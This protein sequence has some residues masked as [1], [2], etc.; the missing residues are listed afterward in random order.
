MKR[1]D[2]DRVKQLLEAAGTSRNRATENEH[3]RTEENMKTE[4][5]EN[6]T[7]DTGGMPDAEIDELADEGAKLLSYEKW[8]EQ[9]LPERVEI[10]E[11]L[12]VKA[13]RRNVA[14]IVK[15]RKSHKSS[16]ATTHGALEGFVSR[17]TIEAKRVARG[18]K[19]LI[20]RAI[21][22]FTKKSS[23]QP[24]M[25]VSDA[26]PVDA[27]PPVFRDLAVSIAKT[28]RSED[29][30][31]VIALPLIGVFSATLGQGIRVKSSR[32]TSYPNVF[33]YCDVG[34]GGIKSVALEE[35]EAPVKAFQTS[36]LQYHGDTVVPQT[37]AKLHK[38]NAKIKA[39][40][41]DSGMGDI[42]GDDESDGE[43]ARLFHEKSELEKELLFCPVKLDDA[44]PELV[45]KHGITHGRVFVCTDEAAIVAGIIFGRYS[46]G[47]TNDGPL[48]RMWSSSDLSRGRIGDN[49]IY[50]PRVTGA[51]VLMGQEHITAKM[52]HDEDMISSGFIPRFLF[53]SC[54][55]PMLKRH[56]NRVT[57]CENARGNYANVID[58]ALDNHWQL[59]H[60]RDAQIITV[61]MTEDAE[62]AIDDFHNSYCD[63]AN[64]TLS[65][66]K[67]SLLRI[68]EQAT[69][70]ALIFHAAKAYGKGTSGLDSDIAN[71]KEPIGLSTVQDAI[72]VVDWSLRNYL[73]YSRPGREDA[74]DELENE[75]LSKAKKFN[76][77]F[78]VRDM[79][80]KLRSKK[81]TGSE[82]IAGIL[83]GLVK[84]GK[85]TFAAGKHSIPAKKA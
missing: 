10:T 43:L 61:G 6:E 58:Y 73:E 55:T 68:A 30:M 26:F 29:K 50:S 7:G 44:T 70:V 65:D 35:A 53:V 2:I 13:W 46:K 14:Q 75:V 64:T 78:T 56:R 52:F 54:E 19:N 17:S 57:V 74:L 32:Y 12:A 16:G 76:E 28:H 72:K 36:R 20:S 69:R 82:Q 81:F 23:E 79:Q 1:I 3:F 80:Q 84:K 47:F 33:V 8:R 67:R 59:T 83:D 15:D 51:M 42:F 66:A 38:V 18:F 40:T 71:I 9:I 49:Y 63:R 21:E 48:C 31:G 4:Q 85:L 39:L 45:I 37:L 11:E 41:E 25:D 22:Q 60:E 77:P 34:S 62:D 27:L 5:N 24:E